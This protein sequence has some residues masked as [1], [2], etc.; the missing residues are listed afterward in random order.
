MYIIY[1]YISTPSECAWAL[2]EFPLVARVICTT[3]KGETHGFGAISLPSQPSNLHLHLRCNMVASH[4]RY[5]FPLLHL[6]AW[7]QRPDIL[8]E[9][10]HCLSST[11]ISTSTKLS[12]KSR[13]RKPC[14][15]SQ[16]LSFQQNKTLKRHG[17]HS[18]CLE[19]KAFSMF[20]ISTKSSPFW[21]KAPFN[22]SI[23]IPSPLTTKSEGEL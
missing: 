10:L 16:K 15:L 9:R 13:H 7:V 2:H 6:L 20:V 8:D 21:P 19:W 5:Q 3:L 4:C 14:P 1:H 11:W 17:T 23:S 22:S 12:A 18:T